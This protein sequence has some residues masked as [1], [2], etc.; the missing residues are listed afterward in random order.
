MMLNDVKKKKHC[1]CVIGI[2]RQSLRVLSGKYCICTEEIVQLSPLTLID[3]AVFS[4]QRGGCRSVARPLFGQQR[5][6]AV[7]RLWAWRGDGERFHESAYGAARC[8][9]LPH[10]GPALQGHWSVTG[11]ASRLNV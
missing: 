2:R 11:T 5:W 1:R 9:P 3:E 4:Y 8:T 7:C 6:L 10:S